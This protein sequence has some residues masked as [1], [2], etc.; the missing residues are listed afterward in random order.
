MVSYRL[1]GGGDRREERAR[2]REESERGKWRELVLFSGG[3]SK[4][5]SSW[6]HCS[7]ASYAVAV[8]GFDMKGKVADMLHIIHGAYGIRDVMIYDQRIRRI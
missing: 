4:I 2:G 7:F 3:T 1:M 5:E 8:D 6:I